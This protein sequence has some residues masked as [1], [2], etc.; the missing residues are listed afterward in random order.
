VLGGGKKKRK[1]AL[2]R[3]VEGELKLETGNYVAP[4]KRGR[5]NY[6]I[7][8]RE[9]GIKQVMVSGKRG[10]SSSRYKEQNR[11]SDYGRQSVKGKKEQC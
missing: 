4:V 10:E 9:S 1:N 2:K 6:K 3:E 8:L 7:G 11:T 5:D